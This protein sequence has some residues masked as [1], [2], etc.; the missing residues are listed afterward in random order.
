LLSFVL[1]WVA[2]YAATECVVVIVASLTLATTWPWVVLVATIEGAILGLAQGRQL[3]ELRP[4]FVRDWTLATIAGVMLGRAIEFAADSS[5]LAAQILAG[6]Y[7][8]Q[9]L[10]GA[11]LGA[12]VGAAAGSFQAVALRNHIRRS[13]RWIAVCALAWSIALPS[14]LLVGFA[15]GQLSG[16]VPVW[17]AVVAILLLFG[18]I[19]AVTGAIEGGALAAMLRAAGRSDPAHARLSPALEQRA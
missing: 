17:H 5:P 9:I 4:R 19:G 2:I 6:P 3:R 10:A 1:R 14:L 12:L 16:S 13:A 15:T 8:L 18:A 7:V 11:A